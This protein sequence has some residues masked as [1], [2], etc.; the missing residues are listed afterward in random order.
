MVTLADSLVS[1]SARP[2]PM[3]MRPDLIGQQQRYQGRPY[4][5]VK[6]P[7]GLNY[8]RFQEE[9]YAIL[10][11]LDGETSLDEIKDR[12]RRAAFRRKKSRVEELGQFI[13]MLHRSGLV[14]ADVAGPGRAAL[15]AP[16]RAQVAGIAGA[17][18]ATSWPSASR[19]STPSGC[20]TG[21]YPKVSWLFTT[22]AR[23]L[24][25]AVGIVGADAGAGAVRYVPR[26]AAHVP[27]VLRGQE[28]D[29]AGRDPGRHQGAFTS[30]ATGCRANISA[31]NATRW[32]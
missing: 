7:V 19:A 32:A 3:R 14:I 20:S 16:R 22:P 10:Q 31:A 6:E 4:W 5:V 23:D 25:H 1:S 2:L 17:R 11:M 15:K 18:S 27:P 21:C 29:L 9:E 30:S 28:L 8:F 12:V 24:L 13:G 26:Q